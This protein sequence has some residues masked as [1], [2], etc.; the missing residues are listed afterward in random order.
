MDA[1]LVGRELG[2][3]AR[4]IITI[5]ASPESD[6]EAEHNEITFEVAQKLGLFDDS[7]EKRQG[8]IIRTNTGK[9]QTL[10]AVLTLEIN[11]DAVQSFSK[12]KNWKDF[13]A[14]EL[15]AKDMEFL[16]PIQGGNRQN[17]DV[18]IGRLGAAQMNIDLRLFE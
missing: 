9:Y 12:E 14:P 1:D 13:L 17:W 10:I 7:V 4:P 18:L 11:H 6:S 8:P 5:Q 16:F 15:I 2:R 3:N